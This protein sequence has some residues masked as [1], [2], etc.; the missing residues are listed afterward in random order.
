MV[1]LISPDVTSPEKVRATKP[2]LDISKNTINF[3][4][5]LSKVIFKLFKKNIDDK[6][7]S[8]DIIETL[9]V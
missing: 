3:Q 4:K 9:Y 6:Y 2:K 1:D 5:D 7:A 8:F